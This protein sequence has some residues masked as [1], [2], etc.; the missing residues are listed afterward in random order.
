MDPETTQLASL[1]VLQETQL[2]PLI[3]PAAPGIPEVGAADVSI[4][5]DIGFNGQDFTVNNASFFTP[6]VPVLLQIMSG[7]KT[8][9]ELLPAGNVYTLPPN[10]VIELSIPGGSIGS[11]VS[12]FISHSVY[13]S[14][15]PY[16]ASYTSSR[17][18]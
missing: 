8:A 11:P 7:V 12:N 2:H 9:Q 3:N 16:L 13:L 4:N 14:H 17:R 10:K 15:A 18:K 6:T 5:L 1:T